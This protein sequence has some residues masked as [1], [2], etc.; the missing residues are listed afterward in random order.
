MTE[1]K[2]TKEAK[3]WRIESRK[4][5]TGEVLTTVGLERSIEN[6]GDCKLIMLMKWIPGKKWIFPL[7]K[8]V[9][10]RARDSQNK[11]F[12]KLSV[13]DIQHTLSKQKELQRREKDFS[14][15][16]MVLSTTSQLKCGQN[17]THTTLKIHASEELSVETCPEKP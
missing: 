3:H 13:S 10:E 11:I 16:K 14:R 1:K 12:R 17:A 2:T 9:V 6:V 15:K 8:L 5:I 4:V 7:L